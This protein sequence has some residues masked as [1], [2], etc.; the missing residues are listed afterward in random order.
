M[1]APPDENRLILET[2]VIP[3]TRQAVRKP[4]AAILEQLRKNHYSEDAIFAI[5]LAF[6]EA[7]A[8][9]MRH[10][11]QGDPARSI[12]IGISVDRSRAVIH[13]QDE[14]RG[15][16]PT[17]VPDPTLPERISLPNG[18]GIML[19]RAYMNHVDFNEQGNQIRMIKVNE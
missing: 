4:E 8:N 11:N 17:L 10:G 16:D 6:Q 5:R 2:F 3:N 18:R 7:V 12:T 19:I 13:I 1:G 9:A 14:G 15:F